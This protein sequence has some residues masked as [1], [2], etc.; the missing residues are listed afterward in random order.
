L[1]ERTTAYR[2]GSAYQDYIDA[3]LAGWQHAYYGA[4]LARLRRVKA[5]YDP[6]EFFR[7]AQSIPPAI[8]DDA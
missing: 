2:S 3:E 8:G 6:D 7:F 5:K 1:Y 4:N